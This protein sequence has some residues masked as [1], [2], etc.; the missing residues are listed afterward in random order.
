MPPHQ[1]V[2][3]WIDE[4]RRFAP[5]LKMVSLGQTQRQQTLD[6]AGKYHVV[7]CSYG[8]LQQKQVAAMLSEASWE[9]VI[10]DEAQAIKNYFTKRSQAAM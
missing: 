6:K 10:L 2:L 9:M 4:A 3:N 5:T 8:L 7:V 1:F